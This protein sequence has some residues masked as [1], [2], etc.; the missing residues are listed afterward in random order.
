MLLPSKTVTAFYLKLRQPDYIQFLC[1]ILL[2]CDQ[3]FL[4]F[5]VGEAWA[6][7]LQEQ[8]DIALDLT[9]SIELPA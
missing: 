6:D 5:V 2:V 1:Q 9:V 8:E 4:Q 3:S 7:P